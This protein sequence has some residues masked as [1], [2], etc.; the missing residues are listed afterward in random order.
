MGRGSR[1]SGHQTARLPVDLTGIISSAEKNDLTTLVNA[2]TENMHRDMSN[3]F[4]SPPVRTIREETEQDHWLSLPLRRRRGSNKENLSVLEKIRES[5]H[6][7]SSATY[8]KAHRTIEKEE[9]EAMTPQL[10]ELKKEALVYFRKWQG[11]VLQRLREIIVNESVPYTSGS[12]TRRRGVRGGNRGGRSDRGG[13]GGACAAASTLAIVYEL[14]ESRLAQGLAKAALEVPQEDDRTGQPDEMKASS[15]KWKLGLG[16]ASGSSAPLS[17]A[18][19]L[20]N[21]GIGTPQGGLG[22]TTTAA[23]GLLGLMA[24]NG[25]LMG[26]LFGMNSARPLGKMLESFLREVQDFAFIRLC[27]SLHYEYTDPRESPV[28]HRRLRVVVAISGCLLESDDI[29]KPWRSLNSQAEVYAIR[30]EIAALMNLGSALET[31]IK[32]TAWGR[33]RRDI[34][35]RTI[36]QSLI[37]STWPEP[38]L[39]ISKIIDNPWGVGMVRA[40]KVGAVL[41]DALIR[42]KFQGD[43]PVSLIGFSLAA[44]AIYACLMVL[45]ERRQFGVVDSVMMLGTPA[46]SESRVWLTLKSVVTGRLINV[47]CESD[48]ILGFLYR[49]SN[50][51]FGVAGLQE[52]QGANG[53]ENHCVKTL[54]RE[55]LSYPSMMG[56]ILRDIGW[57]GLDIRAVRAETVLPLVQAGRRRV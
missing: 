14:E 20:R 43:R 1:G 21:V 24:E 33:A 25:F 41:A 8:E 52:I 35:S 11:S 15:K 7:S 54:P 47:Y 36:F 38:L 39:R 56:T 53:V 27:N 6:G 10:R 32:S 17:L 48:Y 5:L 46:P 3:M 55:H 23:A 19:S 42:Q 12:R 40:E 9:N 26:S 31:V 4:D 22:L 45:A 49:T 51:Q 13:R 57:E 29:I 18:T 2:I 37:D 34:E 30:W 16:S 50:T 44:R 28:E